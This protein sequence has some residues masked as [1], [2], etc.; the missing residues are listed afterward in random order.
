MMLSAHRTWRDLGLTNGD[1][2]VTQK[3][4]PGWSNVPLSKGTE[5]PQNRPRGDTKKSIKWGGM[6]CEKGEGNHE[7]GGFLREKLVLWKSIKKF[8]L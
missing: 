6:Q 1:T 2:C 4:T 8:N 5:L 3:S 7:N